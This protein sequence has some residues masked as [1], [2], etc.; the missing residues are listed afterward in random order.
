M[1]RFLGYSPKYDSGIAGAGARCFALVNSGSTTYRWPK[2]AENAL[3]QLRNRCP[4]IPGKNVGDEAE[5][6]K[7]TRTQTF[8]AVDHLGCIVYNFY[9]ATPTINKPND[10]LGLLTLA[11]QPELAR[12]EDNTSS[13]WT[14]PT[15]SGIGSMRSSRK[16][17]S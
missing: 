4:G 3:S 11:W 16:F 15:I 5:E 1:N 7:S 17:S 10:L 12:A 9:T 2:L 14:T 13:P 8:R 6:L